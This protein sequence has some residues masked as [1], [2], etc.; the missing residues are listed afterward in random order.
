MSEEKFKLG[1]KETEHLL[2]LISIYLSEWDHRATALW[3]QVFK[4]F[5]ATLIVLFLPNLANHLNIDLPDISIKIFPITAF[6]LSWVFL[7][8]SIGCAKRAKD[9][10]NKYKN[11]VAL[12]PEKFRKASEL[13]PNQNLVNLLPKKLR[14]VPESMLNSK[15]AKN[16][17]NNMSYLIC[18]VMFI[19]LVLLSAIMIFLS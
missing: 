12:L 14:Q 6:L 19:A 8:V 15:F 4:Y 16:L 5:Y 3:N 1:E 10:G 9:I 11:L 7:F 17:Y 18:G 13:D 2:Q